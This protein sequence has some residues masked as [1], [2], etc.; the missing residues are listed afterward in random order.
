MCTTPGEALRDAIAV[1]TAWSAS[2]DGPPDLLVECLR[3]HLDDRPAEDALAAATELILGLTNLCGTVLVINEEATG[4]SLR[5]TLRELAL[6][7]AET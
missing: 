4:I 1:M 5:E 7:H 3:G 6:H 2:P